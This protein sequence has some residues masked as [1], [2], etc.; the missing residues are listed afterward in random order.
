MSPDVAKGLWGA[1]GIAPG[2]GP[3]AI[4]GLFATAAGTQ[5]R[6]SWTSEA[7]ALITELWA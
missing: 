4:I 2:W 1:G 3:S 6:P 7:G 5:S